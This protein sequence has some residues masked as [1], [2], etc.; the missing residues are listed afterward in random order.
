[1]KSMQRTCILLLTLVVVFVFFLSGC[2]EES[3]SKDPAGTVDM[4]QVDH[5]RYLAIIAGCNDCHTPGYLLSEGKIEE[6]LWLTGDR[7]GWR[8][9]W[10]TTYAANLRIVVNAM[11]EDQWITIA[12][13]LKARP[14]MPWFALN[15]MKEKDLEALYQ[16]IRY[17][18]VA[19]DPAPAFVPPDQEPTTP[20]AQFPLPPKEDH[21]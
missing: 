21:Q 2:T 3:S 4:K 15:V 11:T 9:P 5:G 7:F 8:G 17:K 16:F 18:G 1:M 20:Y 13:T 14:P 12:R 19:G 6:E 10:G